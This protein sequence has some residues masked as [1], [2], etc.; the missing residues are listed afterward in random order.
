[1]ANPKVSVIIPTHNRS[2][3]LPRSVESVLNQSFSDLEVIIVDDSSTDQTPVVAERLKKRDSRVRYVRLKINRGAPTARNTGIG[4]AKGEILGLLDDD[5]Q[6]L[7][8]KLEYQLAKFKEGPADLGLVY[9][10]Y[11]INYYR[12]DLPNRIKRPSKQ[13]KI[14]SLLLEKC[15]IG[16]PTVLVKKECFK[17]VGR[18]DTKLKSC[19]D[20]D[21]WLR[22]A[23]EYRIDYV[24]EIVANYYLRERGQIT[25]NFSSQVQ[26]RK[27]IFRKYYHEL[28]KYPPILNKHLK[29][30][31]WMLAADGRR[32]EALRWHRKVIGREPFSLR[33]LKVLL[34]LLFL[35]SVYQK[36]AQKL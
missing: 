36:R 23:Q 29:T 28:E 32:K 14:F 6:W 25:T 5:D 31:V 16:S 22:I 4:L 12:S 30:I 27:R 26:G 7:P 18:F 17:K 9:G 21:M 19:Q 13:G 34:A 33:N 35:F 10:G 15:L 3:L 24:D 11:K 1:M 2:D 8:R 20:W